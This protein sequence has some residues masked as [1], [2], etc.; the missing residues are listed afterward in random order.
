VPSTRGRAVEGL[1][2]ESIGFILDPINSNEAFGRAV[3]DLL[4]V[5]KRAALEDGHPGCPLMLYPNL[6]II[7]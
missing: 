1:F 4:I 5:L 7:W 6:F 2:E 3:L